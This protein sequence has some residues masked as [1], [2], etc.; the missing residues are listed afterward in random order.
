MNNTDQLFLFWLLFF[1]GSWRWYV[2]AEVCSIES[3]TYWSWR[4]VTKHT[5]PKV[6][7]IYKYQYEKEC[8]LKKM[9]CYWCLN[10]CSVRETER[11]E[12]RR[13]IFSHCA[14]RC[15]C[16][17]GGTIEP[18]SEAKDEINTVP[19]SVCRLDKTI[20]MMRPCSQPHYLLRRN[21]KTQRRQCLT[22]QM[23]KQPNI[24]PQK[25]KFH[26][27][28]VRLL[29]CPCK[30]SCICISNAHI[31]RGWFKCQDTNWWQSPHLKSISESLFL[32]CWH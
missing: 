4:S 27:S 15:V 29:I 11:G 30:R 1:L 3:F 17:W 18:T 10:N 26:H 28:C 31:W 6:M 13:I 22:L 19:F 21:G 32:R 16:W 23:I 5:G 12:R 20:Q 7:I 9:H 8:T 24:S 2:N 25:K 14:L